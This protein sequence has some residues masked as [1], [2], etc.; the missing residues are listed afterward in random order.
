MRA[1]LIIFLLILSSALSA[2]GTKGPLY[3]PEKAYPQPTTP[4]K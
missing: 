4:S 3:I 1:K 2:C